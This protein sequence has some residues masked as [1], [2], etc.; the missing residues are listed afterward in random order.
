MLSCMTNSRSDLARILWAARMDAVADRWHL[1]N[2]VLPTLKE[3]PDLHEVADET[4]RARDHLEAA[5]AAMRK[6]IDLIE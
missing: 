4:I 6:A 3:L 2:R 5:S 1:D